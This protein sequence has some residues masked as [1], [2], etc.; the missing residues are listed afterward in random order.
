MVQGVGVDKKRTPSPFSP[1]TKGGEIF[2]I[3]KEKIS[4]D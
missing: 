2:E 3:G 4:W 1:P